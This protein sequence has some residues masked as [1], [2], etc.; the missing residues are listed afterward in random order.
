MGLLSFMSQ[1]LNNERIVETSGENTTEEAM[2]F[3]EYKQKFERVFGNPLSYIDS[4]GE[5]GLVSIVLPVY[6]GEEYLDKAINSVLSQTYSKIELIIVND[7]ST[8][9]T[10]QICEKYQDRFSNVIYI[11]LDQNKTLP[12]A[13]NVGFNIANGEYL[14]W[15]SHDNIFLSDFIEKMV[16]EL[17]ARSD[18]GMNYSNIRLIDENDN[19]L[20]GK[21]W[22]EHPPIS[23]NVIFPKDCKNLNVVANNTIGAA[24]LYRSSAAKFL[25]GYAEDRF[26]IEDYDY[27]MRMNEIFKIKHSDFSQPLYLY[28]FH[29]DSLTS[30][31]E[32]MGIT[33]NR[34]SLMEFDSLRRQYILSG[35]EDL[36]NNEIKDN[37]NILYE[38]VSILTETSLEDL[39]EKL[40]SDEI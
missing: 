29:N 14:T 1:F 6:N 18:L 5:K 24:F 33:E 7:G 8:D 19:I 36:C 22:F 12:F 4:V 31:D 20:R 27:W 39:R 10:G 34:P 2:G 40:E 37:I 26:G 38:R 3:I 23:G 21:G 9:A 17:S 35:F 16:L 32:E 15:I 30:K 25:G 28:R 13:L 11:E